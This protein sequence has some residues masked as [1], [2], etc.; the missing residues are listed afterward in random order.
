MYFG[1]LFVNKMSQITIIPL[2]TSF[3]KFQKLDN[4]NST[5]YNR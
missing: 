3:Y 5:C 4:Y 1:E 2:S